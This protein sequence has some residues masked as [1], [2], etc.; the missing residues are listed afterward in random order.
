[1]KTLRLLL[2]LLSA[3]QIGCDPRS[4]KVTKHLFNNVVCLE[5]AVPIL[6]LFG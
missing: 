5:E 1:M 2:I 3:K 6:F 4:A